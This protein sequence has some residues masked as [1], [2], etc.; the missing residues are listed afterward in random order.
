[1]EKTL[2]NRTS[3][4]AAHSGIVGRVSEIRQPV[5]DKARYELE[6][7]MR[8]AER[9]LMIGPGWPTGERCVIYTNG[10]TSAMQCQDLVPS[11]Q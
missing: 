10:Q 5:V 9:A 4:L 2:R 3:E 8:E 6:D 1:M 11:R 7:A